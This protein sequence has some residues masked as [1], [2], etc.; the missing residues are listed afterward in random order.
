MLCRGPAYLT[1]ATAMQPHLARFAALLLSTVALGGCSTISS[2]FSSDSPAPPKSAEATASTEDT[3]A[4]SL[5]GN[6]R[7]AQLLRVQGDYAGAVHALSQLMLVDSDD[8]RI[9]GE[10]GKVLVQQGRASEALP[11]L[12]R[13]VELQSNDW[14]LYSA[15]GVAYD[16]TSHPAQAREAY[17]RAL[18]LKPGEAVVLN[19]FALSRM[20]AGD[21]A[22]ARNLIAQ[23][24]AAG[25]ADPKIARNLG[26]ID[27]LAGAKTQPPAVA[28]ATPTPEASHE[29]VA[30]LPP[31]P[32]VS[33]MPL[34]EPRPLA[35]VTPEVKTAQP[36][37]T[38]VMQQV[39]FDPQAG[40]VAKHDAHKSA[41]KPHKLAAKPQKTPA[42]AVKNAIPAL[43][44]AN[45]RP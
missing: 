24:S 7:Q 42:Q 40:P 41:A 37:T 38:V 34:S 36:A 15:M 2:L 32:L 44:L 31:K 10:Y 45:D 25:S 35:A 39:P 23:A 21:P 17:Q 27:G 29:Q 4:T 11:F 13:A 8:P 19:N 18:A 30:S 9:V 6:I 12:N 33:A 22:E 26:L 20:M 43:R 5:E 16:E 3:A 1:K 28:T 14:T